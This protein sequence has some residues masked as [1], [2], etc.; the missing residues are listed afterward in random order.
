MSRSGCDRA[1]SY[2]AYRIMRSTCVSEGG[3]PDLDPSPNSSSKRGLPV[4][5]TGTLEYTTNNI[6]S[7]SLKVPSLLG[8]LYRRSGLRSGGRRSLPLTFRVASVPTASCPSEAAIVVSL[9]RLIV[10]PLRASALAAML[11]PSASAS[12]SCMV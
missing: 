2:S 7:P 8:T 6:S 9:A 1:A 4:T 11:I 12:V 10:P 5:V 3:A